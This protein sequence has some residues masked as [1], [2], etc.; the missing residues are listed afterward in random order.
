MVVMVLNLQIYCHTY[1]IGTL[2]QLRC[3]RPSH[4]FYKTTI[5]LKNG[6]TQE[7]YKLKT[8]IPF[9]LS[10]RLSLRH[11]CNAMLRRYDTSSHS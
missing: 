8:G 6:W 10:I 3:S 2:Y 4:I 9:L 1:S 11:I 5:A 7:I